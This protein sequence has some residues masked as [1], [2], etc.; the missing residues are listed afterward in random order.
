MMR[1]G[2]GISG[3]DSGSA[4]GKAGSASQAA[5][6]YKEEVS[7]A[8]LIRRAVDRLLGEYTQKGP[9]LEV[10]WVGPD[11]HAAGVDAVLTAG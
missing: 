11:L 2:V 7:I 9:R 5:Q 4:D 6:P 10:F 1:K 3:A 8:E